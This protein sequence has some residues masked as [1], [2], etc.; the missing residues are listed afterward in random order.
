MANYLRT[1]KRSK[2]GTMRTSRT[3]KGVHAA[4]NC[5]GLKL[6]FTKEHLLD[7]NVNYTDFENKTELK[8][9]I[10]RKRCIEQMNAA[11]NG[12]IEVFGSSGLSSAQ[13]SFKNIQP[14][15]FGHLK[16]LRV[17]HSCTHSRQNRN[18]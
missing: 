7:Q 1:D 9:L 12:D 13:D 14:K 5:L 2:I 6:Q 17:L 3:D 11:M 16:G 8:K 15:V 4:V 18:T 10:D